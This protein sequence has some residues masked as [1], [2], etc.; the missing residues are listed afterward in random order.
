LGKW[1]IR[2]VYLYLVSFVTLMMVIIGGVQGFHALGNFLYPPPDYGPS[3][4]L[5]EMKLKDTNLT[6]EMIQQQVKE[7]RARQERQ[8]YYNQFQRVLSSVALIGVG[9]PVYLYHWR[10]IR[11]KEAEERTE[12]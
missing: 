5:Y 12:K 6:P 3:P 4:Y 11:E 8:N 1:E 7:E 10:R 2:T 9:A